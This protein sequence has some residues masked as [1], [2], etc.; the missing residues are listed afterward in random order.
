MKALVALGCEISPH[1]CSFSHCFAFH[2]PYLCTSCLHIRFRGNRVA[3]GCKPPC[4][5][6]E[7]QQGH[8]QEQQV[9]LL[10]SPISDP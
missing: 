5:S 1:F 10:L 6:N 3:D 9:L 7:S 4:E 2:G 8:L